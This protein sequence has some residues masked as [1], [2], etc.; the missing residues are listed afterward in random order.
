MKQA[1]KFNSRF[2]KYEKQLAGIFEGGGVVLAQ[3]QVM[4]GDMQQTNCIISTY[5]VNEQNYPVIKVYEKFV[6]IIDLMCWIW[7]GE[8]GKIR[9]RCKRFYRDRLYKRCINPDHLKVVK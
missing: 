5:A 9:H 8:E 4:D 1:K 7:T 3:R 6:R 2:D